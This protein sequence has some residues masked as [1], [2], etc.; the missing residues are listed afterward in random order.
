MISPDHPTFLRTK[1]H[2]HGSVPFAMA[3][4][5]VAPDQATTYDDPTAQRSDLAFDEGRTGG[6]R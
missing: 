4:N 6:G 3:G 1:T 5:H 2:S